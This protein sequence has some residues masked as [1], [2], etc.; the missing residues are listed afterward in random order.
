MSF[1]NWMDKLPLWLKVVLAIFPTNIL[2]VIYR[3][4]KDANNVT[5]VVLDVLFG[6][7]VGVVFW[8]LNLIWLIT[9]GEAFSFGEFIKGDALGDSIRESEKKG[10]EEKKSEAVEAE[11]VDKE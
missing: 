11:V 1:C 9:K 8:I 2:W 5:L 7:F 6:F 10:N 4:I 3:I